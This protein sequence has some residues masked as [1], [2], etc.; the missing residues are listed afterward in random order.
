MDEGT[1]HTNKKTSQSTD[2]KFY[3][4]KKFVQTQNPVFRNMFKS[5]PTGLFIICY[6]FT[7]NPSNYQFIE[8]LTGLNYQKWKQEFL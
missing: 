4:C 3:L 7:M 6:M 5:Q 2:E 1:E 8:T